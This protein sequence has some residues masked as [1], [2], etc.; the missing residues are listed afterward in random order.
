MSRD[1]VIALQ[2]GQLSDTPSLSLTHTHHALTDFRTTLTS[3]APNTWDGSK[4]S[5]SESSDS[6]SSGSP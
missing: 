3:K 1:W 6:E 5:D 2:R 4:P